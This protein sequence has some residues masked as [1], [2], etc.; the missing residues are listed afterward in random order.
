MTESPIA[1]LATLALS[2][3]LA[4]LVGPR[5]IPA[6]LLGLLLWYPGGGVLGLLTGYCLPLRITRF[7]GPPRE[8]VGGILRLGRSADSDKG[9]AGTTR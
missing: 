3:V 7:S 8:P 9:R 2:F 1:A 6:W 5:W 4:Y